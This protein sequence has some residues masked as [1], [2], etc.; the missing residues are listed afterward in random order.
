MAIFTTGPKFIP[1]LFRALD[2]GN[3][4]GAHFDFPCFPDVFAIA[5]EIRD[6]MFPIQENRSETQ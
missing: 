5:S 3:R 2:P 4:P 1:D 6:P